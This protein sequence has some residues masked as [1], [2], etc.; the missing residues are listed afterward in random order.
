M[1]FWPGI[2][3]K[4]ATTRLWHATAGKAYDRG[5]PRRDTP[6]QK[7]YFAEV[8]RAEVDYARQLRKIARHVGDIIN[9]FPPGD[10]ASLESIERA[11]NHYATVITPWA[12]ATATRM[13][14]NVARRDEVAWTKVASEM[15][16]ALAEEIREAPTGEALRQYLAEQVHLITSLPTEAAERVHNLT[17][18]GMVDAARASEISKEIL[19]SGEVTKSRANLI[20]RTEVARTSSGLTMV[21]AKHV[22]SEGYVWRTARDTDVRKSHKEMEGKFVSWDTPPVLSDGTVTHAGMIYN[23]RCYPEPVVPD[24][25]N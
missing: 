3:D 17:L 11:L 10:P 5:K 12:K 21:R 2:T 15:S 16:R 13:L 25:F 4:E 1:T 6:T 8:R 24:E 19:R 23:C 18:E 22:G 9:G 20:A 14:A 7:A